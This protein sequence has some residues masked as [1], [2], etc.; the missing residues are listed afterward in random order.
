M[1]FI[2]QRIPVGS[3]GGR[4]RTGFIIDPRAGIGPFHVPR[5]LFDVPGNRAL[6]VGVALTCDCSHL[7]V[8]VVV[9]ATSRA[10]RYA[11]KAAP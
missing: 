5:P 8:G 10:G 3:R 6:H 1:D 2:L 4:G 11:P 7:L 9:D